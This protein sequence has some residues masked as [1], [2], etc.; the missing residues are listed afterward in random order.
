MAE[1]LWL[2]RPTLDP[3]REH[4]EGRGSSNQK[5]L[6]WPYEVQAVLG[7]CAEGRG[8]DDSPVWFGRRYSFTRET[9]GGYSYGGVSPVATSRSSRS[10]PTSPVGPPESA[11]PLHRSDEGS[12]QGLHWRLAPAPTIMQTG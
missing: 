6:L 1:F 11:V 9:W 2:P 12:G 4:R 10:L 8:L 3:H 5:Y 7:C